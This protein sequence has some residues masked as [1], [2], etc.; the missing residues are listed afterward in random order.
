MINNSARNPESNAPGEQKR[1]VDSEDPS[2]R[3]PPPLELHLGHVREWVPQL[4]PSSAPPGWVSR[5]ELLI[6]LAVL[7]LAT[8]TPRL[9][10]NGRPNAPLATTFEEITGGGF[11]LYQRVTGVN[12]GGC[13]M[14]R[15]FVQIAH[16]EPTRALHLNPLSPLAFL[17]LLV[18]LAGAIVYNLSGKRLLLGI[19]NRWCWRLYGLTAMGIIA[20]TISRLL[21]AL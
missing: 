12:C 2:P 7:M 15:A 8:L 3:V 21:A 20:L 19:P 16:A 10:A 4:I 13:G 1:V 14:T 5:I 18:K 11:C 6:L 17:W 9:D